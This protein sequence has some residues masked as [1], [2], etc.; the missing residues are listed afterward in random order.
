MFNRI[1]DVFLGIQGKIEKVGYAATMIFCV[2]LITFIIGGSVW[3]FLK[4]RT[5]KTIGVILITSSSIFCS[6]V[7]AP[8]MYSFFGF[9][10]KNSREKT[11][12]RMNLLEVQKKLD[13]KDEFARSLLEKIAILKNTQ[14]SF[15]HFAPILEIALLETDLQKFDVQFLYDENV[16]G[17]HKIQ[18]DWGIRSDFHKDYSFIVQS[19][20]LDAKYGIDL[21]CV[22]VVETED[23]FLRVGGIRAK[24][25]GSTKHEIENVVLERRRDFFKDRKVVKTEILR[26]D[27]S[28]LLA[29]KKA[30]SEFAN[31]LKLGEELGFLN[32]AVRK[33]GENFVKLVFAPVYG[34]KIIFVEYAEKNGVSIAEFLTQKIQNAQNELSQMEISKIEIEDF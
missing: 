2:I 7:M 3:T 1:W 4:F 6:F 34:E 19:H 22:S 13:E 31:R 16:F 9:A 14:L 24:Y 28:L 27:G 30:E 15:Q 26:D 33:L 20:N 11:D 5:S 18:E 17:E 21:N 23:G 25:I 10:E 8:F 32:D 29:E 12:V